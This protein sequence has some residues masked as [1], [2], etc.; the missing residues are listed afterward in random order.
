MILTT[1]PFLKK[2][3]E[4][5]LTASAIHRHSRV[6]AKPDTEPSMA[7]GNPEI[8]VPFYG[9]EGRTIHVPAPFKFFAIRSDE[10]DEEGEEIAVSY[11]TFML[12]EEY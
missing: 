5:S 11:V 9:D 8:T 1:R 12:P 7:V 2:A 3:E 10:C 4:R 6:V